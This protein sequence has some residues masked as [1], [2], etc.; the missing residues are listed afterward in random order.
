MNPFPRIFY[1]SEIYSAKKYVIKANPNR[2]QN[3]IRN[4]NSN[5]ASRFCL[6]RQRGILPAMSRPVKTDLAFQGKKTSNGRTTRVETT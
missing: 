3:P 4:K 2:N 6:S 5:F 1:F